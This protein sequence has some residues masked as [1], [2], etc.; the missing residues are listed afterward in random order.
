MHGLGYSYSCIKNSL[1]FNAVYILACLSLLA[2]FDLAPY[3]Y[4]DGLGV[5]SYTRYSKPSISWHNRGAA[6]LTLSFLTNGDTLHRRR[7]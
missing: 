7:K 1:V 5:S 4:I 3:I 2:C 6:L